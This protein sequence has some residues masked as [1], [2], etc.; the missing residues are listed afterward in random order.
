MGAPPRGRFPLPGTFTI[1]SLNLY[2][3]FTSVAL[4]GPMKMVC[5]P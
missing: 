3:S 1:L 5:P 4:N 2:Q